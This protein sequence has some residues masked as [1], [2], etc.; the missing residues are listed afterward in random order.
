MSQASEAPDVAPIA[1]G[2]AVAARA[3]RQFEGRLASLA[4]RFNPIL[5]KEARQALK[6]R[7]FVISFFLVLLACWI[8]SVAG[9]ALVGPQIYYAAAGR[10]M[11]MAYFVVLV[12]PLALIV[13]FSAFRSLAAEQDDNTYDLLSIS[14]LSSRQIISGKLGS[15][16]VQMLV[17]VC[18][19]TPCIA[20]T[21]LLRG[22]DTLS[23]ALL[24]GVAMLGSLGLSMIALLVGTIARVR[25]TQIVISV[26]L[27][28]LLFWAGMGG[29]GIAAF[30]LYE[31]LPRDLGFWLFVAFVLTFYVTTFGLL[32]AA[33][34]AQLAF[35]SENRSTPMRWWMVVQQ[36]CG[37]AWALAAPYAF[38][39]INDGV[40]ELTVAALCFFVGYWYVLG[41]MITSEWPHLSRR[42]QRALPQSTLG[43][44]FLSFFNPGPGAGYMFVVASYTALCLGAMLVVMFSDAARP[45]WLS[46]ETIVYF[47]ILS[48]SY[49]VA[50]LGIGRLIIN[51]LRR[52]IYVPI[53][54]GFLVHVVLLL[55]AIGVPTVIQLTSRDLRFSGYSLVQISNPMW[56][57]SSLLDDGPGAVQAELLALIVPAAA[58]ATLALNLRSVG[59]ELMHQRV[60]PPIRVAEEEAELHPPPKPAPANPWEA[61]E[62]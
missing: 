29:I 41:A 2:K 31:N 39:D 25:S 55:A 21:Y 51:A 62:V 43:R 40:R 34:A 8:V 15:A 18:A 32:H 14:A 45:R 11:L 56:T 26:G 57:L 12:V 47:V 9:V 1:K 13:P 23:I 20:F 59:A 48:W 33:A 52:W 17:Y 54:A 50:F 35:A 61:E 38:G 37:F 24:L 42:V 5:V 3:W 16:A 19:V 28:I 49:L 60:A 30:V 27:V 6:S 22:V 53:T 36:A 4:D 10:E 44:M 46:S 58:L 7:Q